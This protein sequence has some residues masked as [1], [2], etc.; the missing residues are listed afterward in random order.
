[1]KTTLLHTS[2]GDRQLFVCGVRL[3]LF[4]PIQLIDCVCG[5]ACD[6]SKRLR[7]CD[8]LSVGVCNLQ[9]YWTSRGG[10]GGNENRD[11]RIRYRTHDSR[12]SAEFHCSAIRKTSP[13]DN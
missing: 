1:M 10:I 13:T 11:A 4:M 12:H 7:Q 9:I 5:A 3:D 8:T 2:F 6:V